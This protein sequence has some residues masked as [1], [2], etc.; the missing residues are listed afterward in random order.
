LPYLS[1]FIILLLLLK[2]NN[3]EE[4]GKKLKYITGEKYQYLVKNTIYL[5][6]VP[7]LLFLYGLFAYLI[8]KQPN[9]KDK[10]IALWI[11]FEFAFFYYFHY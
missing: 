8:R 10:I 7:I 11:L 4:G 1:V 6:Y 2:I 5:K 3:E 9:I